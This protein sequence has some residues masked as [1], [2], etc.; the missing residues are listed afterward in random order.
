ML[1]IIFSLMIICSIIYSFFTCDFSKIIEG[2]LNSAYQTI[3]LMFT[4]LCT[5]CLFN[6]MMKV[7]DKSG[8]IKKISKLLKKPLKLIFKDVEDDKTFGIM[9]MNIGANL[10]GMGNAATPFG[11]RAMESLKKDSKRATNAMCL[12]AVM[13]TASIQIIPS[14]ILAIRIKYA[15]SF[16][17]IVIIP[18]WICSFLGLISGIIMCRL[19]ER[20]K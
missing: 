5:M 17:F 19:S 2:G 9:S 13:N 1:N 18:I 15:S 11:I 14:T 20:R 16:P 6:G 4:I 8:M 10:L 12:F 7:L 3:E